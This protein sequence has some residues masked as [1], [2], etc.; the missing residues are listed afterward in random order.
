MIDRR[1]TAGDR[2]TYIESIDTIQREVIE[3]KTKVEGIEMRE[4]IE[5]YL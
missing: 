2:K 5:E 3:V 1:K 4:Y